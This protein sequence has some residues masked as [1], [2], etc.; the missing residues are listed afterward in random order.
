MSDRSIAGTVGGKGKISSRNLKK[1]T[2]TA[3]AQYAAAVSLERNPA[4][5]GDAVI[6]ISNNLNVQSANAFSAVKRAFTSAFMDATLG[7]DPAGIRQLPD[8]L[9]HLAGLPGLQ[10]QSLSPGSCGAPLVTGQSNDT[11]SFCSSTS[12]TSQGGVTG[13]G[14][15][16]PKCR[17]CSDDPSRALPRPS[18]PLFILS[19]PPK[20][21][22]DPGDGNENEDQ[23]RDD[24]R[25]IT[26][27]SYA[28]PT[29]EL[30]LTLFN[31]ALTRHASY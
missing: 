31:I 1:L 18:T 25:D 20:D 8:N 17:T 27:K 6:D 13:N 15:G 16:P 14:I 21:D 26:E 23:E 19:I 28:F 5:F 9:V 24:E 7:A 12:L 3:M 4:T 11:V 10:I 22:D 2:E 30:G 29:S